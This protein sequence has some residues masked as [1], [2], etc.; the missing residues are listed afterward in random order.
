MNNLTAKALCLGLIVLMAPALTWAKNYTC[1]VYDTTVNNGVGPDARQAEVDVTDV[2]SEH[3][4]ADKF[5][6]SNTQWQDKKYQVRCDEI[7]DE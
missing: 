6:Q 4:A 1:R 5:L 2:D 3:A 7:V